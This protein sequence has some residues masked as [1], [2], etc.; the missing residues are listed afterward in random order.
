MSGERDYLLGTHDEEIARLGLQH[1]VWRS[2]AV[3]AWR[4]GEFTAGQTLLDVGCGP[5]HATFDLAEIAGPAGRVVAID[6]SRRF[7]NA[8]ETE[9]RRRGHRNITTL[10]A[11]LDDAWP[12]EAR[13]PAAGADGA[14]ARWVFAFLK[15]PRDLAA[16]LAAALRPGGA[17]VLHEYFAYSTWRLAPRCTEIEEFV[18]VVMESWRADGG[19]P[20]VGLDLPR[21]LEELGFEVRSLRPLVDV[22]PASS[23]I[24]QWPKTFLEVGLRRLVDLGRLGEDRAAAIRQAFAAREAEPHTLMITP[25]VLEIVA[26]RR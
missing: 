3:E 1:R 6:R 8:L 16:R 12:A 18:A 2:R 11:D 22:V 15:R 21:W 17:L 14:W 19:E 10:E 7:L 4:R 25:A 24:W 9:G 26:V 20:D 23:R 5:G 13:L